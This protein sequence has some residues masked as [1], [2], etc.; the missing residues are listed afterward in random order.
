MAATPGEIPAYIIPEQSKAAKRLAVLERVATHLVLFVFA[1]IV[2]YPVIWMAM[3]S[4]KSQTDLLDNV[5]GP[6]SGLRWANYREAWNAASL[7]RSLFNSIFVSLSTVALVIAI[8]APAG[9]ALAKFR[10]KF[11]TVILLIFVL[12]MQAP[13]PVIPLYVL[14]V[15]LHLTNSYIGYILPLTAGG[16]PLAVFVF[17]AFFTTIPRDLEDAAVVDGST[18]LG[19]FLRIVMPISVPAVATVAILQ[20]LASWN[21]YFLALILIRSPELRTLPLSIQVFFYDWGRTDWGPI[22]AALSVGS[23]P[24][25]LLY[26]VMQRR[27]VQGLTAGAVKG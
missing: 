7:G 8:A 1:A 6:P 15:K 9:Y 5:W 26:I 24:M 20:F 25:I 4:V 22:F 12:T 23:V 11:G 13:V 18:Q 21:E 14:L 19:A 10:L 3:A 16:I 2:V 17:R 27:F